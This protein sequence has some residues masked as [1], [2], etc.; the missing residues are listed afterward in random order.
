MHNSTEG[1]VE[2][3]LC[4]DKVELYASS[5]LNHLRAAAIV[6]LSAQK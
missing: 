2:H 3:V 5:S 6:A 4:E 1:N